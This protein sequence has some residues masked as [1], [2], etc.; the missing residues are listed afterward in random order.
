MKTLALIFACLAVALCAGCAD[1]IGG[2]GPN[3]SCF[4]P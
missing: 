2:R 3:I 4:G 1:C